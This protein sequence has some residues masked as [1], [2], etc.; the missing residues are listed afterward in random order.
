MTPARDGFWRSTARI[1]GV[2]LR[3]RCPQCRRGAI[4]RGWFTLRD[5]CDACGFVA[6][7]GEPDY[8]IGAYLVNLIVAELACAALVAL[9]AIATWPPDWNLVLWLA[10][11]IA[12]VAPLLA[13]PFTVTMWLAV[14]LLLRPERD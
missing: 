5:R 2:A 14:D 3:R 11:V 10:I 9:F 13:Y 4:W 12:V 1:L 7:R 8:F 6:N